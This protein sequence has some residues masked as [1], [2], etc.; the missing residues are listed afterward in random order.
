MQTRYQP[1]ETKWDVCGGKL[2][3]FAFDFLPW[4]DGRVFW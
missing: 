1:A 4:V 3:L 2:V